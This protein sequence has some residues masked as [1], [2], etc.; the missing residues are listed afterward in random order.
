M[1][2]ILVVLHDIPVLSTRR[3]SLPALGWP[4]LSRIWQQSARV[5]WPATGVS[6]P[7]LITKKQ[8]ART[9]LFDEATLQKMLVGDTINLVMTDTDLINNQEQLFYLLSRQPYQQLKIYLLQT[10]DELVDNIKS[11]QILNKRLA[12]VTPYA[13]RETLLNAPSPIWQIINTNANDVIFYSG[14][15]FPQIKRQPGLRYQD[16]DQTRRE[17]VPDNLFVG[18]RWAGRYPTAV[19]VPFSERLRLMGE[20]SEQTTADN[21]VLVADNPKSMKYDDKLGL[22]LN[23]LSKGHEVLLTALPRYDTASWW[24]LVAVHQKTDSPTHLNLDGGTIAQAEAVDY[25]NDYLY[26]EK[27]APT[28]LSSILR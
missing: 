22:L 25:I 27:V 3:D 26:E 9:P 10:T 6:L 17:V 12:T 14:R 21:I 18:Q 23:Q 4:Q 28:R 8:T 1:A 20:E 16:I 2:R 19:A 7:Q 13:E 5:V 15:D 11:H 24:P